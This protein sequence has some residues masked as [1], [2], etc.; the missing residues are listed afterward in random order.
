MGAKSLKQYMNTQSS[1]SSDKREKLL[2][3]SDIHHWHDTPDGKLRVGVKNIGE[4]R[5]GVEGCNIIVQTSSG[6]EW[7]NFG[8]YKFMYFDWDNPFLLSENGQFLVLHWVYFHVHGDITPVII[9]LDKKEFCFVA[10][11]RILKV[12]RINLVT[13]I[14]IVVCNE[15]KW[16]DSQQQELRD[17]EIPITAPFK[18]IGDFYSL[19]PMSVETNVYAWKDKILTITPLSEHRRKGLTEK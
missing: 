5:M 2:S 18:S 16:I 1:S 15:T 7:I 6:V 8:N 11:T 13:G 19:D 9:N 14:P 4:I 12:K 3:P 17:M 10:P